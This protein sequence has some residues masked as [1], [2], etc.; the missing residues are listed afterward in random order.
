MKRLW[1]Y[2]CTGLCLAGGVMFA[3]FDC[4]LVLRHAINPDSWWP[5]FMTPV[6]VLF[7]A[8]SWYVEGQTV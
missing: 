7:A 4:D 1:R 5:F 6:M 3:V 8:I 2:R